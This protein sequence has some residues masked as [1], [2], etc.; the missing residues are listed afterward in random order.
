VIR[1]SAVRQLG[2]PLLDLHLLMVPTA[3]LSVKRETGGGRF[4]VPLNLCCP[5][6]GKQARTAHASHLPLHRR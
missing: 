1:R 6:N 5:R 3:V 2:N 4:D